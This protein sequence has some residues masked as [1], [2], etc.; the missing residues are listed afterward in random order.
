MPIAVIAF[1]LMT[2]SSRP[3]RGGPRQ[4]AHIVPPHGSRNGNAGI[5]LHS[6][7]DRAILRV[8]VPEAIFTRSTLL[9]PRETPQPSQL[10]MVCARLRASARAARSESPAVP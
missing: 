1:S 3:K 8:R 2:F 7:V 10:A 5:G 9:F 6:V 4:R